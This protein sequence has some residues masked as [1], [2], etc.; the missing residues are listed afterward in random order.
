[1][2]SIEACG[3]R[4]FYSVEGN[5]TPVVLLHGS[6]A[7]GAQ[8]KPMARHLSKRWKVIVPDLPGYGSSQAPVVKNVRGFEA[9][10]LAILD[11]IEHLGGRAH[12]VGHSMGGAVAMRLAVGAPE[13]ILSLSVIEP[14][15]FHLLRAGEGADR[16]LFN[17]IQF[18]SRGISASVLDGNPTEGV[19][20]F[21]DY[22]NEAGTWSL[23]HS[24]QRIKASQSLG[25]V[26]DDFS[27]G[28]AENWPIEICSELD[29]PVLAVM[30][31]QGPAP[32]QRTTEIIAET[33][34]GAK[35]RMVADGGHMVPVTHPAII[36]AMVGEFLA[37]A[38][39]ARSE[40]RVSH[41]RAA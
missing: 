37:G 18:L 28:F 15:S 10:A 3:A 16:A 26:I 1:M 31:M 9:Y 27:A 39:K 4:L 34:P 21:I 30:G 13:S 12:V 20:R 36:N 22:W 41:K 7:S 25:R 32:A 11:L 8:W 5:G 17:E 29:I 19:R 40:Y 14:A 35:L 38:G 24:S 23:M 2:P 6:A 33:V